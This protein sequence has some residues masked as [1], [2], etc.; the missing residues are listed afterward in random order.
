MI[1]K[2][3]TTGWIALLLSTSPWANAEDLMMVPGEMRGCKL[4]EGA[5]MNDLNAAMSALGNW[6]KED[7]HGYELWSGTP[8]FKPNEGY[9]FDMLWMGFWTSHAEQMRGLKAFYTTEEGQEIGQTLNMV[10]DCTSMRHF[11]SVRVRSEPKEET[12]QQAFGFMF[13]CALEA[14]KGPQ[15]VAEVF[16]KWNR[17]LDS[18]NID[19]GVS[20]IF[21][22]S[23]APE[24]ATGT[25]KFLW[26]GD[27]ADVGETL[28]FLTK[29]EANATWLEITGSTYSCDTF[30]RGYYFQ[31]YH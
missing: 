4:A 12:R 25:F 17:Y 29:P 22:S 13:D 6:L 24:E 31:R 15:D 1:K 3:M 7:E 5:S 18:E 11:N 10:L 20:A 14:N 30:D 19:H 21:P 9:D 2:L 28:S 8:H 26:G 23:G 27:F 16:Q